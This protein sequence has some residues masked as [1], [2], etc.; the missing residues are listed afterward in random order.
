[1]NAKNT[2]ILEQN[3][4]QLAPVYP[5]KKLLIRG[6]RRLQYWRAKLPDMAGKLMHLQSF[7]NLNNTC[8]NNFQCNFYAL[9]KLLLVVLTELNMRQN[10]FCT[11][12]QIQVVWEKRIF[13]Y[14]MPCL[15]AMSKQRNF[16]SVVLKMNNDEEISVSNAVYK[17]DTNTN[18][19]FFENFPNYREVY[20]CW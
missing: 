6:K 7:G 2:K 11:I 15:R 14:C 5:I 19:G 18:A 16:S 12:D 1:M 8:S 17:Y 10:F 3:V 9:R 20:Q 13:Y 4:W